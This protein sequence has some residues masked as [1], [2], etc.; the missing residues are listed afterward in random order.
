MSVSATI[1]RCILRLVR[2]DSY[3]FSFEDKGGVAPFFFLLPSEFKHMR[4]EVSDPI[5]QRFRG[6]EVQFGHTVRTYVHTSAHRH[7]SGLGRIYR[8]SA[9]SS[10]LKHPGRPR[11]RPLYL[12]FPVFVL[13]VCS[14]F[15]F[16]F[17]HLGLVCLLGCAGCFAMKLEVQETDWGSFGIQSVVCTCRLMT[18]IADRG[19]WIGRTAGMR[20]PARTR[21]LLLLYWQRACV[22]GER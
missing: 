22:P 21:V 11:P 8:L 10:G 4:P 13:R 18:E 20:W 16:N 19:S 12:H 7:A 6:S 5:V 2:V 15:I 14:F 3:D 1:V 9:H 17:I